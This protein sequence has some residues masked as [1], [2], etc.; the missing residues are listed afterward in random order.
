MTE[1]L[2]Q[3]VMSDSQLFKSS[4][5][6]KP[7][8]Y[9]H[10][11]EITEEH[12]SAHWVT[13][14]VN[15]TDDLQDWNS[16][17]MTPFKKNLVVNLLRFF[18]QGDLL[19]DN[20]FYDFLIPTFKNNEIRDMY[21]SFANREGTHKRAYA[22]LNET[23]NLP[24]ADYSIFLEISAMKNK[25]DFM[26]D[27][28]ISTIQGK[29]LTLAKAVFNE[30]VSLFATFAMLLSFQRE[31]LM[32]KFGTINE[33][34][35]KDETIHVKGHLFLFHQ[36]CKEH[37]WIVTD[38]FKK[39]IYDM[40]R[41]CIELEDVFIDV[42]YK[43]IDELGDEYNDFEDLPKDDV[44]RYNRFFGNRRLVQL[45]LK[46]NWPEV[47][48]NP[49]EWLDWI[50]NAERL[51]NFFEG[52]ETGYEIKPFEGEWD[53]SRKFSEF[54][55]YTKEGCP[56]C[57]K[58]KNAILENGH[59]M[60][61][62]DLSDDVEREAFYKKYGL[63]KAVMPKVEQVLPDGERVLIGGLKTT[64]KILDE[65]AGKEEDNDEYTAVCML[66]ENGKAICS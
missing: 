59:R 45:G 29:A 14:A 19:V 24:E 20:F 64:L 57:S 44:K 65:L 31:G 42:V 16:A 54:I 39:A 37:P 30:G 41:K 22:L 53:Y 47:E 7:I 3:E 15:I 46:E 32:R 56:N 63:Q 17:K 62:I 11:V 66:G 21:G 10:A 38:E 12:E 34:S 23:L 52:T 60:K 2:E 1:N 6:Y 49:F 61:S 55:V 51:T 58:A 13:N 36:L 8:Y 50:V 25:A 9:P 43:Y 27:V 48:T 4:P 28:D 35:I 33:W 5:T 40:A 18:T 26:V